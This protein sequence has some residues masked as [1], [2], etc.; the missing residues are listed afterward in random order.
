MKYVIV[1]FRN[2][3]NYVKVEQIKNPKDLPVGC[4]IS[5]PAYYSRFEAMEYIAKLQKKIC[6]REIEGFHSPT[7][8]RYE[9]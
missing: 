9:K 4:L 1:V 5:S 8:A 6:S 7:I 2:G 3:Y